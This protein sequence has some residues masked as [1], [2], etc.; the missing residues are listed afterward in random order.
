MIKLFDFQEKEIRTI[1]EDGRTWFS[2]QDVFNVLELTWK[3]ASDMITRRQIDKKHIL[4]KGYETF[5]GIQEMTFINEHAL[6]KIAL[7]AQKSVVADKFVDWV[8]DL[9]VNI[10]SFAARKDFE[11]LKEHLKVAVQKDFSK[12]INSK[13]FLEGGVVQTVEYNVNNC[14]YHTNKTPNEIKKIG[15][16]AGL[17]SAERSSAKQV[18]RALKPQTACSMSLTDSLVK[19]GWNHKEAATICKEK[20]EDLFAALI[21]GGISPSRL[22][23][24]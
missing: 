3:G 14:I 19:D 9:L 16:D 20:A 5:G 1:Q 7:R 8:A 2:G 13:N 18:I 17:K 15:K 21:D 23:N 11:G 4:K 12:K 22:M 10:N 24:Q 6:Y